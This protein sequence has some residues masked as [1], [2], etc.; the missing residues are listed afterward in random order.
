MQNRKIE[1]VVHMHLSADACITRMGGTLQ[2]WTIATLKQ[3]APQT[4][5]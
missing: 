2:S 5:F 1:G 3:E 4:A